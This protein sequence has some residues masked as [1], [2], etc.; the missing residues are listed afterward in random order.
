M[1][2]S[3]EVLDAYSQLNQQILDG[4]ISM[5]GFLSTSDAVS[6]IG[7]EAP[8]Y[9]PF[10]LAHRPYLKEEVEDRRWGVRSPHTAQ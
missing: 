5:D 1:Q 8:S 3:Q 10:L 2:R 7:D 6:L 9:L 4:R